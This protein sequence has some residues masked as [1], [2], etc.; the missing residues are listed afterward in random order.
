MISATRVPITD[1][2]L[3]AVMLVD[4]SKKLTEGD[5]NILR[6][7]NSRKGGEPALKKLTT[8]AK[9]EE[10]LQWIKK[11]KTVIEEVEGCSE[12][13]RVAGSAEDRQSRRVRG[14]GGD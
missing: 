4:Y 12:G 9:L 2:G 1:N 8:L 10:K 7:K 11:G 6:T 13:E 3:A 14:K 5:T